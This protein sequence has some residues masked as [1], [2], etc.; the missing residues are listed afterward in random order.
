MNIAKEIH[1]RIYSSIQRKKAYLHEPIFDKNEIEILKKCINSGYVSTSGNFV[2]KFEKK[3][4]KLTKSKY[5]V[6]VVNG[7]AA[8]EIALKVSDIKL[9]DEVLVPSITFVGTANAVSLV[10]A[11]PH[12]IDSDLNNLGICLNSL[13]AHLKKISRFN[14]NRELINKYTGR[15]I[16][17]IIPVHIYG[18]IID[19]DR[20]N[21]ISKRYKLTV[22]EDAAEALGSY[23]KLR[24][25]GTFGNM[26]IISFN[27]NKPIT[28]GGGG[29]IITDKKKLALKAMHLSTIC[30]IR[31]PW[32]Y[33]HDSI[34]WN[35]RMP[36]LNASLGC[37]QI[38]KVKKII[39]LKRKLANIYHQN[40]KNSKGF[41]IISEPENCKSNYW[42]NVIRLNK[43]NTKN[44]NKI[45]N[46]LIK[47]GYQC[48]PIWE[49][50]HNLPMYKNC[51]RARLVNAEKIKKQIIT[52]PSSPKLIS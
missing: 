24:H 48:R 7:T 29:A 8:L 18:N 37:A 43:E 36:S 2:E 51:P 49:P 46:Y 30:K 50:L 44:R 4:T 38:N 13:E 14:S 47:K 40:F 42:L 23:Y 33:Y 52:I 20:L 5:A 12:F 11:I 19:M 27:G 34:G 45:I 9:G 35:Y 17:A 10:N 16:K 41:S 21:Y 28:T 31:H 22:I 32:N 1:R 26:G 39:S 3:I 6:A 25:A 15:K